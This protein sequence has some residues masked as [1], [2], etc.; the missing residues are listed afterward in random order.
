ME[1]VEINAGAWYL[2]A[3]RADKRVDDRPALAE[4]GETDA[5]YIS[6]RSA[7]WHSDAA[8]FVGCLRADD[9][10]ACRRDPPRPRLLQLV[11]KSG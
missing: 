1:P 10:R 4:L 3:L 11:A 8:Y 2:R 6:R 5:D 7:Q 9:G